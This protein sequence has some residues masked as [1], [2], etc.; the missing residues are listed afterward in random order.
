MKHRRPPGTI[1]ILAAIGIIA[2]IAIAGGL[3]WWTHR[4]RTPPAE[5]TA[6]TPA[7]GS[8][9]TTTTSPAAS[10]LPATASVLVTVT[11]AAGP[12][13]DAN[14]RLAPE[15]GD[16]VVVR[17]DR[18][19]MAHADKLAVGRWAI[20]ASAPG[21]QPTGVAK[22][23]LAAGEIAKLALTLVSGGR[24]LVGTVT[25][26]T[27]GPIAGVRIDAAKLTA[28]VQPED[29]VAT[30]LTEAD[31]TYQITVGEGPLLVAASS[32][33]YASQSQHV[34]V[35]AAGARADFTL[36]PGGTL[37]GIVRD[38]RT[39]D[40][41][42]G[43]IVTGRHDG[44]GGVVLASGSHRV[45]TGADGRF[46]LGGLRPGAYALTARAT[47]R[48]TKAPTIVGIGVAEQA[49]GV[50]LLV[51]SGLLVSGVVRDDQG[52]PRPGLEV[53]A[54]GPRTG[55]SEITDEAGAFVFAELLP[56][57]YALSARG[58]E[59]V[60]DGI[61]KV[62]LV[63]KDLTKLE[64]R[65]R[66]GLQI[67]GHVEPRQIC[68]VSYE[69]ADDAPSEVGAPGLV[70]ATTTADGVFTLGPAVAVKAKLI[71][72]CDSGDR[73]ALAID[74]KPGDPPLVLAVT[75]GASIAG[76]VMDTKGVPM[77]GA[78]VMAGGDGNDRRISVVN[79]VVTSG[80]Q[81]L[82]G[83]NGEYRITGLDAGAYRVS[84][85]DRGRPL[86]SAKIVRVT[87]AEHEAK[88]G[89]DVT[90]DRA[91]GV[92]AGVV[93]GP[94][95]KPL[96]EAW[97]SVHQDIGAMVEDLVHD[98]SGGNN[99][100]SVSTS[101]STD[102]ESALSNEVAPVLTDAAG[103]FS[104]GNLPHG[105]FTVLAEAQAGALRGRADHVKPDANVTIQALGLTTVSGT[106]HG[107]SGPT[108]IFDVELD[109]PTR[110]ARTFTAGKF[111]LGRVDPGSYTLRIHSH[112]G[113]ALV[114]LTVV[115]G[116]PSK[117]DVPLTANA[118]VIGTIVGADGKPLADQGVLLIA[119]QGPDNLSISLSGPPPTSNAD[120]TFRLE[121]PAVLSTFVVLL[122][123]RPFSKR[124]L[125]LEP[126][127]V[128]DLGTVR[129]E[130]AGPPRP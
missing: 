14:V 81:A 67:A 121:G 51:G 123:P 86:R 31:G 104:I 87:L 32:P 112:D 4:D 39:Q 34:E 16:V 23:R 7:P 55:D 105:A 129:V 11:S 22:R 27:G 69:V 114:P 118:I 9:S 53:T 127:K 108:A 28:R 33:D 1:R 100:L 93:T 115:A 103:R 60:A 61:T 66:T 41:V 99:N 42:A 17:T 58:G 89:V 6:T 21:F 106:V 97:V 64:V 113:N 95:G 91:D 46:R 98:E 74:P 40:P 70:P 117:V 119:D 107:A 24:K 44:G 19:G 35:G 26:V 83:A 124:P 102:D 128:L 3:W 50:V 43:A 101:I 56:G 18:S 111:E 12:V 63:D 8:G 45:T 130:P 90:V 122:R 47:T 62:E 80:A 76:H 110:A 96:A 88:T 73:G 120:G 52:T 125:T 48:V 30:T 109:G 92:I 38:E 126:G 20:S 5:P 13:A 59:Y 72:R 29:A 79:G 84:V 49:S 75:G 71:A 77:V 94:E 68:T 36:V 10:G 25:D 116:T 78:Q 15:D 65:V 85:L 57:P 2:V 54:Q 82:S 37:E